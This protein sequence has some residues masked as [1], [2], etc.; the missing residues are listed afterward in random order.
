MSQGEKHGD[1]KIQRRMDYNAQSRREK[2]YLQN[3]VPS[4][5][6]AAE[7]GASIAVGERVKKLRQ[8]KGLTIEDVCQRTGLSQE[9]IHQIEEELISPPLGTLIRLA[10][11]L[12]MKMGALISPAG[13]KP[14]TVVRADERKAVSRYASKKGARLGYAYQHLAF[15]KGDRSMEPFLLTLEPAEAKE[16]RSSHEGEEFI[17]VLEGR[18]EAHLGEVVEVLDPGDALYYD[19][20]LPHLIK[21]HGGKEATIL[22]VLYSL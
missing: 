20:N 9:T 16:E 5:R 1:E 3:L 10:R 11:A 12:E 4:P 19:S 13:P 7:A 6:E 17:F 8:E 21:C 22:A 15:D 2:E 14:F 18:V